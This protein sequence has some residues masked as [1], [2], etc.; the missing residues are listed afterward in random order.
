MNPSCQVCLSLTFK[1]GAHATEPMMDHRIYDGPSSGTHCVINHHTRPD[2]AG[3]FLQKLSSFKSPHFRKSPFYWS[4]SAAVVLL[5]I[6]KCLICFFFLL[7][8]CMSLISTH[9]HCIFL[10]LSSYSPIF[11]GGSSFFNPILSDLG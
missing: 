3:V 10:F 9:L 8:S 5:L 2:P 11:F 4:E 1:I 6:T 7:F